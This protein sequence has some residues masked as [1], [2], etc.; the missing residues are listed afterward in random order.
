MKKNIIY[1]LIMTFIFLLFKNYELVLQSTVGAVEIWLYK[2]FPYLFIM[3]ILNDILINL[4]FEK[5]FKKPS[6]YVFIMSILSG[7]PSSA[8]ITK[9]LVN[10]GKISKEQANKILTFTYFSNPLFLYTI[11][12]SIFKDPLVVIKLMLIHYLSNLILY[13]FMHKKEEKL[14][15]SSKPVNINI[16]NSIKNSMNTNLMILGSIVFYFVLSSII[17]NTF[18]FNPLIN[19]ILRGILELTQGLNSLVTSDFYYKEYI[20]IF[21]ISFGGLSIHTQVKCILDEEN[22]DYMCFFKGRVYQT[23]IALILTIITNIL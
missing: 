6:L 22:L 18:N 13:L 2:V 12:L 19:T 1:L 20:A 11:L 15:F 10:E 8:Y 16:S 7:T 5:F 21:F 3:I 14:S 17:I 9:K 4:N 23:I